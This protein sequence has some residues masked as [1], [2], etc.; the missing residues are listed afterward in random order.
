MIW[1]YRGAVLSLQFKRTTETAGDISARLD[2]LR[3]IAEAR[4]QMKVSSLKAFVRIL[5]MQI[6][7][8]SRVDK[9]LGLA[10]APGIRGTAA[11]ARRMRRLS[12]PL[13]S[14][15]RQDVLAATDMEE[16]AKTSPDGED[17]EACVAC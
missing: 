9:S 15:V 6:A 2:L 16:E 11:A 3:K 17:F 10:R 14:K 8:P 4:M 13:G 5:R 12:G 1:S 7:P